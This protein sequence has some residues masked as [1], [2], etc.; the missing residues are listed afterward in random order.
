MIT[1]GQYHEMLARTSRNNLRDGTPVEGVESGKEIKELHEPTMEYLKHNHLP[2][3][4][5]NPCEA[6]GINPGAPDFIIFKGGKVILIEYKTRTGKMSIVQ[7]AWKLLAER[8]GF[9]VH[10]LRSMDEFYAVMNQK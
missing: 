6:S 4:H 9:E 10:V 7:L 1:P 2:Y 8:E 3:I 5:A